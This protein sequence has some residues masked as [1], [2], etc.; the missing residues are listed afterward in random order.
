ME[1]GETKVLQ[2]N[3]DNA[4][5]RLV[6]LDQQASLARQV[7]QES[8]DPRASAVMVHG[9]LE[10]TKDHLGRALQVFQDYQ[11]SGVTREIQ[12]EL[13]GAMEQMYF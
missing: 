12:V 5:K 6:L 2:V 9:V 11:D 10:D 8:R 1:T 7:S 3:L 4:L 13:P